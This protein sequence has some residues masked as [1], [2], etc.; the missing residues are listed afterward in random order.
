MT[1]G[2]DSLYTRREYEKA[3]FCDH[4]CLEGASGWGEEA[5]CAVYPATS[6]DGREARV[7]RTAMPAPFYR[8]EA[9]G[10]SFSTGSSMHELAAGIAAALADGMLRITQQIPRPA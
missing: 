4:W 9:G 1:A 5:L 3:P 8:I 2:L 7:Y 10:L 6:R